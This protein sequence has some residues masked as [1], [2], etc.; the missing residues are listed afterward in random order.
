[1]LIRL[2][3]T[4]EIADGAG[5]R[6]AGSGKQSVVLAC[7]A[8][9]PGKVVAT[10]TLVNRMWGTAPPASA[11][12]VV[13]GHI[14]RLRGLFRQHPQ[15]GL[16]RASVGG[17]RLDLPPEE[18]D[19]FEMRRLASLAREADSRS[20][21][22]TAVRYWREACALWR[23]PALRGLDG[24]WAIRTRAALEMER[25]T[26]DLSRFDAELAVGRHEEVLADL[27]ELAVRH[28]D[29]EPVAM[30]L[31][32]ALYRA[33]R[34]PEA[35]ARYRR[36][37]AF[38]RERQGMEP[39]ERL[40]ELHRRILRRD[41]ELAWTGPPTPGPRPPRQLPAVTGTFVG[42]DGAL[43][44]V[45][46]AIEA[47]LAGNGG[48]TR[49][50]VDGMA[51]VGKTTFALRV[52]ADLAHRFPDGQLF[53]DLRG[54][55]GDLAPREPA[56]VLEEMLRALHVAA[57][58][59]EPAARAAA[60]RSALTG[61]RV[62]MVL[63][64]A[65][66]ADQVAPLLPGVSDSVVLITSRRMLGGLDDV[67]SVSLDRL[68]PE[69][70]VALFRRAVGRDED[71]DAVA[72][73]VA[74]CDGL[75]LAIRIAAGRL[76]S[77]PSWRAADLRDRLATET[78]RLTNL[79]IGDRSVSRVF[80]VTV[81]ELAAPVRELFALLAVVPPGDFGIRAVAATAA[82]TVGEVQWMLDEL[83]DVH[84]LVAP[85]GDRY[86]MHDLVRLFSAHLSETLLPPEDVTSAVARL[87]DW[88]LATVAHATEVAAMPT[89]NFVPP[90]VPGPYRMLFETAGEALAWLDAE[91]DNLTAVVAQAVAH[92]H[93]EPA[94]R[95][96]DA[97]SNYLLSRSAADT[98]E[99]LT[100]LGLTAA[101][102]LGDLTGRVRMR[103]RRGNLAHLR[104]EYESLRQVSLE[105]LAL[106]AGTDHKDLEASL[107]S[108]LAVAFRMTGDL[109]G[110]EEHIT[111]AV[112]Y[113]R[114][115]GSDRLAASLIN[116]G[117]VA[118]DLGDLGRAVDLF[119]EALGPFRR[120]D[121][122][123]LPILLSNMAEIH[124]RLGNLDRAE[125]LL[126]EAFELEHGVGVLVSRSRSLTVMG[127]ILVIRGRIT[128]AR[129]VLAEALAAA[130]NDESLEW[131]TQTLAAV[132]YAWLDEPK[133]AE[134]YAREGLRLVD[135]GHASPAVQ[136]TLWA[137]LASAL[138]CAGRTGEAVEIARRATL[139]SEQP[140]PVGAGA[141]PL[142][143][144]AEALVADGRPA[145][146][147]APAR[148]AVES[149]SRLDLRV[150]L[151]RSHRALAAAL[152]RTGE[153]VPGREHAE[154]AARLAAEIGADPTVY[155]SPDA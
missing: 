8:L 19:V 106:M 65:A 12:G 122:L 63:D 143:V 25:L 75:P 124:C 33:D 74:L 4:V 105:G 70:G 140:L 90:M 14:T 7:L 5:W 101:D 120:R 149:Q 22:D 86:R 82:T 104:G 64:D 109:P 99:R 151:V 95:I 136:F 34:Q 87:S 37:R 52:A 79:R 147:V 15:V 40:A 103:V 35:L 67:V 72:E 138:R 1:M 107:R 83:A 53:V 77:R 111:W 132:T 30:R 110:A 31:L 55:A 113:H 41:E 60:L 36:I 127:S 10:D 128:Q 48:V 6:H 91:R 29:S 81:R 130:A 142:C 100:D 144:L 23:G 123:N 59:A 150:E 139:P 85:A 145:E 24:G 155:R 62:L 141:V 51:G 26:L 9:A 135:E 27:E 46:E 126:N 137:G 93:Y 66:S 38:L 102:T 78:T 152:T 76:R 133:Q 13:Y 50:A 80:D 148:S 32:T 68:P 94:W 49:I 56:E 11:R 117:V 131:H 43:A 18:I 71:P 39:G 89:A 21:A 58:P 134:E 114:S 28:P 20:D 73:L 97:V 3:G 116:A 47:G 112:D 44:E 115:T 154:T 92:G 118:H 98:L 54:F 2:L 42:R 146:A 16:D 17:Y 88:Y 129:E 57:V 153:T 125:E 121:R 96:V 84:L 45:S 69:D 108:Q 119:E 61:R